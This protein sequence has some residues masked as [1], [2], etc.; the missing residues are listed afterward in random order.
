MSKRT[1]PEFR[2]IYR[3][4]FDT[5]QSDDGCQKSFKIRNGKIEHHSNIYHGKFELKIGNPWNIKSRD[6]PLP[7][8]LVVR[9]ADRSRGYLAK[10]QLGPSRTDRVAY[11]RKRPVKIQ[12]NLIRVKL[13]DHLLRKS[14]L[15][16]FFFQNWTK[17]I[18]RNGEI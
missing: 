8:N 16:L 12:E 6:L 18:H 5:W 4:Q 10:I 2:V 17:D 15:T 14:N 3:L 13:L 7:G 1:I 9:Q 11:F